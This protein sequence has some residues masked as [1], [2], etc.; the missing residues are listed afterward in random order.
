MTSP[1]SRDAS[2]A[3]RPATG[4]WRAAIS[5]VAAFLCFTAALA[6]G[7]HNIAIAFIVGM[8]VGVAVF[9]SQWLVVTHRR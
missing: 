6:F 5:G 8:L 7:T 9:V 3:S 2:P 4:K 1:H